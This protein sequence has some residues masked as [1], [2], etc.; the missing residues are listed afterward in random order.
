MSSYQLLLFP[1]VRTTTQHTKSNSAEVVKGVEI[2]MPEQEGSLIW[3]KRP[4]DR[5]CNLRGTLAII[6]TTRNQTTGN[7]ECKSTGFQ[8]ITSILLIAFLVG[9]PLNF[10]EGL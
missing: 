5:E 2:T 8:N 3:K 4:R 6:L 9:L 7:Q 10:P 1:G